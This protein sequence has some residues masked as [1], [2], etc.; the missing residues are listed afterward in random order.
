MSSESLLVDKKII[1]DTGQLT[2]EPL[3]RYVLK[4]RLLYI[5]L[6]P[7]LVY[8]FIF[9]YIP[10]YGVIIAFKDFSI[11]KGIVNSPWVGFKHFRDLFG[12]VHFYRVFRNSLVI[13]LLQL[14]CGFPV[15]IFIALLLNE[16]KHIA[17]KR[18]VQTIIYVPHFIW[19]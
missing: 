14:S 7:G 16:T 12:S 5:L 2:R 3:W 19:V 4:N 13:S 8:V 9:N 15:P 18:A 11:V 10:I 17:F 1:K 6:I